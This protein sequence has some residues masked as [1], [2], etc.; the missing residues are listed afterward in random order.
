MS[1]DVFISHSA[2]DKTVADATCAC[3]EQRGIRCWVAPRDI[4]AGSDWSASIIDGINGA[5]VMVLILS[6]HSNV[7]KQVIREIERAANRGIPI[8]PF[9][10]D[11]T[12]LSKSLEYFLSS[13]HWLDAFDGELQRHLDL[14]GNNVAQILS[15]ED[16]LRPVAP[17][18]AERKPRNRSAIVW[19]ACAAGL[20]ATCGLLFLAR[21]RQVTQHETNASSQPASVP[22]TPPVSE[23]AD[24]AKA[25]FGF[26]VSPLKEVVSQR[27]GAG[28]GGVWVAKVLPSQTADIKRG[29]IIR[30]I[31]DTRLL[32]VDDYET[33]KNKLKIGVSYEIDLI[34]EGEPKRVQFTPVTVPSEKLLSYQW[35]FDDALGFGVNEILGADITNVHH[36]QASSGTVLARGIAD[37]VA[38][39]REGPGHHRVT[40]PEGHY[41]CGNVSADGSLIV[42]A[43][44]DTGAVSAIKVRTG[45]VILN[46]GPLNT[47][48][49]Q[50]V[51]SHDNEFVLALAENGEMLVINIA[52][53]EVE[54]RANL[55]GL[56]S[57]SGI[58]WEVIK[59]ASLSI[60]GR[61]LLTVHTEG[62][63]LWDW[64]D[65]SLARGYS[66][67]N[68]LRG[69][70][71]S[72]DAA[73]VAIF[74]E[75]GG[76][77]VWDNIEQK[78]LA[79]VRGHERGGFFDWGEVAFLTPRYLASACNKDK[80][81]R[82][83]DCESRL[84]VWEVEL[85]AIFCLGF[86]GSERALYGGMA[87]HV[88][89]VMIPEFLGVVPGTGPTVDPD[90][91]PGEGAAGSG[92]SQ[93]SSGDKSASTIT[94]TFG[95]GRSQEV[96]ESHDGARM[97]TERDV[98]GKITAMSFQPAPEAFGLGIQVGVGEAGGSADINAERFT[99]G[100]LVV[101]LPAGG[102][103]ARD[104][105]IRKGDLITAVIER[106]GAKPIPLAGLFLAE[107][108]RLVIGRED[109][110]IRLLVRRD[111][112]P[113]PMEVV[114]TRG[115][116]RAVRN[117]ASKSDFT[118]SIGMEFVAMPGG[119]GSLGIQNRSDATMAP[120]YVRISK[121]FLIGV[122][123]VTQDEY[124]AVMKAR[125]SIFGPGG[126]KAD[127]VARSHAA[128]VIP[129]AETSHHPVD[130]VSWDDATEFCRRLGEKEGCV[131]RLP[132]EAE[133][134]WACRNAGVVGWKGLF[135]GGEAIKETS[136]GRHH[137]FPQTPHPVGSRSPNEAGIHDMLGNVAEWCVDVFAEDGFSNAAC[138]DPRGPSEGLKR[139]VRGGSFQD[140]E[141]G[142]FERLGLM[143]TEKRPYV[144]FRVVLE[145]TVGMLSN[146]DVERR[147][148]DTSRWE[149]DEGL[150][151]NPIP[152]LPGQPRS[153]GE[154]EA[155]LADIL[156]ALDAG[157]NP[158][159]VRSRII[160]DGPVNQ[161]QFL[162]M[163]IAWVNVNLLLGD[164]RASEA[165][166]MYNAARR[167]G[168]GLYE[169]ARLLDPLLGW[170]S[171][172][173][174]WS[175]ATDQRATHRDPA[176]AFSRAVEACELAKWQYWG[177]LDTLS[178]ALAAAGRYESA[179]RVAKAALERAP[180]DEKAQLEYAI[181]RYSQGLTWA[182]KEP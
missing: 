45:Q 24:G 129:S 99:D 48:I 4:V 161:T 103:A 71:L 13:A 86:D 91:P 101:D 154:E 6:K 42:L 85:G 16:A 120:H 26:A 34:R 138:V 31:G 29:D 66:S 2:K 35:E 72:Q 177:F 144:G 36:V 50:L 157:S 167:D 62:C 174:A 67:E 143:P 84:P 27:L 32:S 173:I 110:T 176:V 135:P 8:L 158:R 61:Y 63:I 146:Q 115:R 11:D 179:G 123:E 137:D 149:I 170:V 58:S 156:K 133:W 19:A 87:G 130:S 41:S 92:S 57:S 112:E 77:E 81:V 121:G 127:A 28:E 68:P 126:K 142:F 33:I 18:P 80:T 55:Q 113:E 38:W 162:K 181:D 89:D 7:S 94:A 172:D 140:T 155:E 150:I 39:R 145:P 139:V 152:P 69:A 169:Q 17:P 182:A 52:R 165:I 132:T 136:V 116:M 111:G 151:P 180:E 117:R 79:T 49:K 104:A 153:P 78:K 88:V 98:S 95:D 47:K 25:K 106:E 163:R 10:V 141:T 21:Q 178:A 128:G 118:N 59:D 131:Y 51:V 1:H 105:V 124:A 83:W 30:Q 5:G 23:A 44:R 3:L 14:L 97:I 60:G 40:L 147:L 119:I 56:A 96:S 82:I 90:L 20:I 43:E 93:G 53:Q 65:V 15:R 74:L 159:D 75:S 73:R 148:L 125:P 37:V 76:I 171:N 114:A 100:A 109:T 166:D 108:Q 54:R 46:T 122:H 168:Y 64:Q 107:F 70:A 160:S 164:R 102:Q 134:E 9:R 175:L 22:P 12:V